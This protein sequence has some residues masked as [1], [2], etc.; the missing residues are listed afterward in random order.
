M[1]AAS[2]SAID[3]FWWELLRWYAADLSRVV[4]RVIWATCQPEKPVGLPWC[5]DHLVAMSYSILTWRELDGVLR[6]GERAN[7]FDYAALLNS[8]CAGGVRDFFPLQQQQQQQCSVRLGPDAWWLLMRWCTN[9]WARRGLF[10]AT[11]ALIRSLTEDNEGNEEERLLP[12]PLEEFD[13]LSHV[14]HSVPARELGR[15]RTLVLLLS[16]RLWIAALSPFSETS[17]VDELDVAK[18]LFRQLQAHWLDSNRSVRVSDQA[19]GEDSLLL[20]LCVC[21]MNKLTEVKRSNGHGD[22]CPLQEGIEQLLRARVGHDP[23]RHLLQFLT[24]GVGY[25]QLA[26]VLTHRH[27]LSACLDIEDE[28]GASL[29]QSVGEKKLSTLRWHLDVKEE[30]GGTC[31]L[32][33]V[34]WL[35]LQLHAGDVSHAATAFRAHPVSLWESYG[36]SAELAVGVV[37]H[38]LHAH[39]HVEELLRREGVDVY[40]LSLLCVGR[41]LRD[42]V[43]SPHIASISIDKFMLLGEAAWK[44]FV[45]DSLVKYV[46]TLWED[47]RDT[48]GSSC[49]LVGSDVFPVSFLFASCLTGAF[50]LS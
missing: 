4:H 35:L 34:L 45:A 17:V 3:N 8:I 46:M 18:M 11:T 2:Q 22:D 30:D 41:W 48:D 40:Y 13:V 49:F 38:V 50:N 44:C 7:S 5:G 1:S 25:S 16:V 29:P 9:A 21:V 24:T 36:R 27:E 20:L 10:F 15:Q 32:T 26:T 28:R 39:P 31:H 14:P 12:I 37:E 47:W 6:D 42:P 23:V 19:F 43:R 33:S